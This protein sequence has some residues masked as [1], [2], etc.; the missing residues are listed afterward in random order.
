MKNH[1]IS[2]P[3]LSAL[4]VLAAATT[5]TGQR[6]ISMNI[7]IAQEGN[8]AI[9][10]GDYFGVPELNSVVTN[11]NNESWHIEALRWDDGSDSTVGMDVAFRNDR[12]F[13]GPGYINTPLNYGVPHY[14]GTP[15]EPG[16][17]LDFYNLDENFPEG[18]FVIVYV[19]GFRNPP[20]AAGF[21]TNGR[22]RFYYQAPSDNQTQ[23]TPETLIR[24]EVMQDPGA[25][26]YPEAHY[27]VFGGPDA[28]FT[29]PFLSIRIGHISGGGV[30]LGGVQIV[31]AGDPPDPEP[32][33]AGYDIDEEGFV[34][35]GN[36][37]LGRLWVDTGVDWVFSMHPQQ[38][39]YT[40][41]ALIEPGEGG[42]FFTFDSAR[43]QPSEI[44]EDWWFSEALGTWVTSRGETMGSG[45][46]WVYAIDLSDYLSD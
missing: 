7:A 34:D 11:W 25:G 27:A 22:Q 3:L 26:N 1:R 19:T 13:F 12:N 2:L 42:W 29:T 43:L 5:V 16:T 35:T 40:E 32:G 38:W 4:L 21:V 33:W 28:P 41:S 20:A 9:D 30:S 18:Y 23:L 46:E 17:G 44:L 10:P 24:T 8:T 37:F 31:S 14:A 39:I 6:V 15:F 36:A 45:P